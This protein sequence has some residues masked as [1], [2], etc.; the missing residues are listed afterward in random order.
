M[1]SPLMLISSDTNGKFVLNEDTAGILRG[2]TKPVVVVAIVGRY[3]TGKSYLMN[4]LAGHKTGFALGHT[5]QSHTKGIW[6]WAFPHP[7]DQRKYL[8][9]LDTEGLGD[10][11]KGSS[12]NDM[13]LFVMALLLSSQLVFNTT[14]VL[15]KDGLDQLQLVVNLADHMKTK[16]TQSDDERGSDFDEYL[17]GLVVCIRDFTLQMEINGKPCTADGYLNHCLGL[18]KKGNTQECRSFNEQRELLEQYFP[19][20]RCLAFPPPASPEDMQHLENISE[21]QINQQFL[22]TA[23][24]FKKFVLL[25][26]PV[27]NIQGTVMNGKR[28]VALASQYVEAQR[29]G[30]IPCIEDATTSITSAANKEALEESTELYKQCMEA[31]KTSLPLSTHD[32]GAEHGRAAER[33]VILFKENSV[34]DREHKYEEELNKTLMKEY[35]TWLQLNDQT[36]TNLSEKRL[37]ELYQP[38]KERHEG[39]EF[40]CGGG[41]KRYKEELDAITEA[42]RSTQGL[43]QQASPALMNFLMERNKDS[44]YIM[45]IDKMMDKQEKL[46]QEQEARDR[47]LEQQKRVKEEQDKHHAEII[48]VLEEQ[49][50]MVK[51]ELNKKIKEIEE[52]TQKQV[53]KDDA[54]SMVLK[55]IKTI[56]KECARVIPTIALVFRRRM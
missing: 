42:F 19:N 30:A 23:D 53:N 35:E 4:L 8:L 27:K 55:T 31:I 6:A 50:N 16:T 36:S 44:N 24:D 18:R 28:F 41:Y 32:L 26:T 12:T 1:D 29:K 46:Q 2:I 10:V 56:V 51:E 21:D 37:T 7:S 5:V 15:S 49:N 39:G 22:K 13:S 52:I 40:E 17:P 45:S 14:S 54:G 34:L 25:K 48:R 9:L 43:G 3:R 11:E 38:L 20:R 47:L 33:A